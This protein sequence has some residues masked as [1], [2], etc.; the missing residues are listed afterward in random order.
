[1]ALSRPR[2]GIDQADTSK[3]S[4]SPA[5]FS[6]LWLA[7]HDGQTQMGHKQAE[8]VRLTRR[9]HFY[10]YL[11]SPLAVSVLEF[12]SQLAT[13]ANSHNTEL[14]QTKPMASLILCLYVWRGR[15]I[16]FLFPSFPASRRSIGNVRLSLTFAL[17]V[18]VTPD[19]GI[20]RR[21]RVVSFTR[22][23]ARQATNQTLASAW[24]STWAGISQSIRHRV[25]GAKLSPRPAR[26][27]QRCTRD[28]RLELCSIAAR[29]P[30]IRLIA[31]ARALDTLE[32]TA[33]R[34]K[35]SRRRH[36]YQCESASKCSL[37]PP[38]P[39]PLAE[40]NSIRTPPDR[41]I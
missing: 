11:S 6:P 39:H 32:R 17:V 12:G 22:P 34:R 31:R 35:L 40:I 37:F 9:P 21:V 2:D 15:A 4:R 25:A 26:V 19:R 7:R 28:A 30:P 16:L 5:A 10:S 27:I 13:S 1:M 41:S 20:S 29:L 3:V 23:L 33:N 8:R 36:K 14:S 38:R 18:V 24:P